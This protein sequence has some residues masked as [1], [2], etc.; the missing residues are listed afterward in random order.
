V[1]YNHDFYIIQV[2]VVTAKSHYVGGRTGGLA[3]FFFGWRLVANSVAYRS[4]WRC[5]VLW[6]EPLPYCWILGIR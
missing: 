5:K 4:I 6:G 1:L 3:E 2:T